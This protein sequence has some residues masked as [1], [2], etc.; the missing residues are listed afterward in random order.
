MNERTEEGA[1]DG[2]CPVGEEQTG[3]LKQGEGGERREL[4]DL[5][6]SLVG[7]V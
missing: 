3:R 4:V 6:L 1:G 7:G 2:E 5:A